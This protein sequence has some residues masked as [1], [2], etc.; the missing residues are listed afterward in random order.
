MNPL[1]PMK[2][3]DAI[4]EV[5]RCLIQNRVDFA[6]ETLNKNYPFAPK[7]INKKKFSEEQ[8]TRIFVRDGFIDQY[9]GDKLI[10]PPV[11]RVLSQELGKA[12][13]FHPHW[14]TDEVHPAYWALYPEL[15]HG[16]PLSRGGEDVETNL[17]TTSSARNSAKG[18]WTLDELGWTP[19]NRG[20]VED[21]DGKIVWFLK[22]ADRKKDA[23]IFKNQS[24]RRW[25]KAAKIVTESDPRLKLLVANFPG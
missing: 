13:P 4:S 21:W 19:H 22:Y 6:I 23:D 2:P 9:S 5:C 12:F 14:K 20:Q 7:P 11:F 16:T 24:V 1:D 8:S 3:I 10:F 18:N 25:V 17:Y 15:D